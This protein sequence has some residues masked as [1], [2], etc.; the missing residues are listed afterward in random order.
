MPG[1]CGFRPCAQ[2][3]L[4]KGL[5]PHLPVWPAM[6][7]DIID[8]IDACRGC[9]L[10]VKTPVTTFKPWPK[11]DQPWSRIHIEFPVP[12][13]DYYYLTLVN[14]YSKWPEVLRCKRP[15]TAVTIG[16][17]YELNGSVVF[18]KVDLSDAYLQIPVE[19]ECSKLLCINTHRGIY[20]FERLAFGIKV[21][22]AIFQ[23]VIDT[24]LV[25]LDFACAY[26]DD[27]VIASKST[28]EAMVTHSYWLC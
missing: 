27:I 4:K 15:T 1:A 24:M 28:E 16:F 19:E 11:T 23:Q 17:L 18:S 7:G 26:L 13:E 12:L 21:T 14:S 2:T 3:H 10:A 22:P 20:K 9:A 5:V 8:M 6:D 25:G